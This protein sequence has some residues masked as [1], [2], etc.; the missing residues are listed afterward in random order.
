MRSSLASL[1]SPRQRTVWV[2]NVGGRRQSTN[3]Y[4]LAYYGDVVELGRRHAVRVGVTVSAQI[5][6]NKLL[7]DKGR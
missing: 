6:M 7:S 5:Q 4:R 3:W 1:L 2:V